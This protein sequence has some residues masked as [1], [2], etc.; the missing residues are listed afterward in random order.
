VFDAVL[1]AV[2]PWVGDGSDE[3]APFCSRCGADIGIFLKF[4]LDWR[5]YQGV[6]VSE[7]ELFDPSHAPVVAWRV[8]TAVSI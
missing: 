4:G 3:P 8:G 1:D 6:T 7:V 5:H 2:D